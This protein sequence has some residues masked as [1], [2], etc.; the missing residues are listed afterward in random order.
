[1][2]DSSPL[3]PPASNDVAP[4]TAAGITRLTSLDRLRGEMEDRFHL[5]TEIQHLTASDRDA[6]FQILWQAQTGDSAALEAIYDYI[7][8]EIPVPMDEFILGKQYLALD[9]L[10]NQ[11]KIDVLMRIDDPR[12]RRAQLA[13]GSGG[14]KS[15]CVSIVKAR[16]IYKLLCLRKPDLFYMLGPGSNIAVINLSISKE[17]ARDVIFAEFKARLAHSP[18]FNPNGVAR[19][20]ATQRM[21]EFPKKVFAFSG[22]SSATSYYGYHTKMASLDEVSWMLDGARSIA[23][24]LVEAVTKSMETRFPNAYLLMAIS[25]LRAT[26]DWL[27]QNL[28]RLREDGVRVQ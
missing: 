24:D 5:H 19:Y 20:D 6:L 18:W 4:I 14:G 23:E 7:Y 16:H 28:Q 12:V 22:G 9:G 25:T 2:A 15:F 17:Q 11:E 1:M 27:A 13:V 26:D 8:D 3:N 21:A 10:I